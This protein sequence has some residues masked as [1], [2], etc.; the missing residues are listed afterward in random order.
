M[1]WPSMTPMALNDPMT[2]TRDQAP[3]LPPGR[4]GSR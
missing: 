2:W 1:T 4:V 3:N